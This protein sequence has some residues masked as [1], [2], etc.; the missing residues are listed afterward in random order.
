MG[1]LVAASRPV[2]A[3]LRSYK[4][5]LIGFKAVLLLLRQNLKY[6]AVHILA[7][8]PCLNIAV[9]QNGTSGRVSVNSMNH[10]EY[11]HLGYDA[12]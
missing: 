8:L 6:K 11:H 4:V 2:V 7:Y 10:E 9:R 5:G 1:E 12:V 3:L